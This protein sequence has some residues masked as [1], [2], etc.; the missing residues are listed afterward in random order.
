MTALL[1]RA[2]PPNRIRRAAYLVAGALLPMPLRMCRPPAPPTFQRHRDEEKSWAQP[3]RNGGAPSAAGSAPKANGSHNSAVQVTQQVLAGGDSVRNT[4]AYMSE[5][6]WP[7]HRA[8]R[9][10]VPSSQARDTWTR[11]R[12]GV[13]NHIHVNKR[14]RFL[15]QLTLEPASQRLRRLCGAARW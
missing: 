3:K 9:G 7:D 15:I 1:Y 13:C 8:G 14:G 5:G 6:R 12:T 10:Q 4:G 2:V 11:R